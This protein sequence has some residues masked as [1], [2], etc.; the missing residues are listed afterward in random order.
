MKKSIVLFAA[1]FSFAILFTACKENKK[2]EIKEE[3]KIESHEGHDHEEGEM[4]SGVYQC[5]MDCEKGKTYEVAGSCPVCKMDLKEIANE[6]AHVEGCNCIA[7]GECKCEDGKCTCKEEMV[8]N[9]KKTSKCEP[10]L[11]ACSA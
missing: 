4:T 11:C 7:S 9:V 5:P 6:T 2:E 10:G 1:I 8:S 3:V